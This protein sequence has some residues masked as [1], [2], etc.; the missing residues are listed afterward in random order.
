[1]G[2]LLD[3]TTK[4]KERLS[5]WIVASVVII[6]CLNV[7]KIAEHTAIT[8]RAMATNTEHLN[9]FKKVIRDLKNKDEQL[10]IFVDFPVYNRDGTFNLASDIM[11]DV[12][13]ADYDLLTRNI[14]RADF[15]YTEAKEFKPNPLKAKPLPRNPDFTF[16]F[17]AIRHVKQF[18]DSV[19]CFGSKE[20]QW[21]VGYNRF[22]NI[23]LSIDHEGAKKVFDSVEDLTIGHPHHVVIEKYNGRL[24]FVI[25][26]LVTDTFSWSD[27]DIL[28]IN[29]NDRDVPGDF[30]RG[31]E[32]VVF[33][34]QGYASLG[35]AKYELKGLTLRETVKFDWV[36][37]WETIVEVPYYIP[38]NY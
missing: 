3:K 32:E 28:D 24:Y 30:Y 7:G 18:T 35:K 29:V 9:N 23:R 6:V 16:E 33:C 31:A 19:S 37:P 34:T 36:P 22:G 38:N 4:F 8:S 1:L 20:G 13:F 15:I 5:T 14:Y 12:Y 2:L 25:D 26:G 17:G 11:L 21:A 27:D 10:K